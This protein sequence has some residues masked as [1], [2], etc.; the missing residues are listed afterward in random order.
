MSV[1][2]GR[3]LAQSLLAYRNRRDAIIVAITPS[4]LPIA[5]G[6]AAALNVSFDIFLVRKITVPGYADVIAGAVARGAYV[7][8]AKTMRDAGISLMAF[9]DAAKAAERDIEA[10]EETY[11]DGRKAASLTG[12]SVILVDDGASSP[13]E[14]LTAITAIRRHGITG[15]IVIAPVTR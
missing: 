15:I 10:T 2:A 8:S 13:D 12:T 5:Q 9:V 1:T 11:R 6:V 7:P 4:S 3:L 14:L